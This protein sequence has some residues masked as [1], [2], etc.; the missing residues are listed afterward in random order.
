L[1][2]IIKSELQLEILVDVLTPS[3]LVRNEIN[4]MAIIG[5]LYSNKHGNREYYIGKANRPKWSEIKTLQGSDLNLQINLEKNRDNFVTILYCSC[6]TAEE[7]E[8][9]EFLIATKELV[10]RRKCLNLVAAV[11][12]K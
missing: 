10:V 1:L 2:L 11:V 9:L 3:E 4:P 6:E 7:T 12:Y 8:Q 5:G